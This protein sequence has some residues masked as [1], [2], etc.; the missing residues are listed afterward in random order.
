MFEYFY[1]IQICTVIGYAF[2]IC[3][4]IYVYVCGYVCECFVVIV[5]IVHIVLY[6]VMGKLEKQVFWTR[7]S[8]P[9]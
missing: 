9:T 5:Y 4:Y 1:N 2:I 3:A 6:F 8:F 7:A